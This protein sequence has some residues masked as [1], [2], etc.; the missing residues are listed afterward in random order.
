MGVLFV[1]FYLI[2]ISSNRRTTLCGTLDYLPPEMIEG[3]EHDD[4]VCV[5]VCD[6]LFFNFSFHSDSFNKNPRLICGV[7]ACC[8]TNFLL[9]IRRSRPSFTL[10]LTSE[11]PRFVEIYIFCFLLLLSFSCLLTCFAHF[12]F[13]GRPEFPAVCV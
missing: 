11:F 1:R 2:F 4:K 5:C 3:K 13:S 12:L 8:A 7:W 6:H 9:A 10:T